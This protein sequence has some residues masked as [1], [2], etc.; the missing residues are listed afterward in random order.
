[1]WAEHE[2]EV[3]SCLFLCQDGGCLL[4][5]SVDD[6]NRVRA[7]RLQA[8]SVAR[9]MRSTDGDAIRLK[10]RAIRMRGGEALRGPALSVYVR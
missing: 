10:Q 3:I 7:E 8:G 5:L 9:L 2:P 4:L 6:G 1:L